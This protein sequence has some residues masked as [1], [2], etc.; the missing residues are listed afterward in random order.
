MNGKIYLITNDINSHKYVGQTIN[1]LSQRF[2]EHC[3]ASKN[4][5]LDIPLYRAMR[6]YGCEHFHIEL[7]DTATDAEELD[8]KEQYWINFYNS[9]NDGYNADLGGCGYRRFLTSEE[10]L[11]DICNRYLSGD[12]PT[13]IAEDYGC[14]AP[15]VRRR[16]QEEGVVIERRPHYTSVWQIDPET[17]EVLRLFE[18]ISDVKDVGL[19]TA[20]GRISTVC[21]GEA[22]T[23]GGYYWR[24]FDEAPTLKIG[25]HIKLPFDSS[26]RKVV[27]TIYQYDL[28]H[29]LIN[30]FPTLVA[31]AKSLNNI[32]ARKDISEACRGLKKRVHPHHYNGFLWYFD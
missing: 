32:Y 8:R 26:Q 5:F 21:N 17:G 24:Y 7:I 10:E 13:D 30:S 3:Y 23:A 19:G 1:T 22:L 29:N 31:A 20:R 15:T 12:K 2:S 11:S 18:A 14:S 6:K 4:P 28:Q 9:Y 25:Q 27:K 16:L